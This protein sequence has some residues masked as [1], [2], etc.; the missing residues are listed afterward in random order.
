MGYESVRPQERDRTSRAVSSS[1]G[2]SSR[3]AKRKGERM[4]ELKSA[5]MEWRGGL[6]G[7]RDRRHRKQE[8][9]SRGEVWWSCAR[10][11]T[12]GWCEEERCGGWRRSERVRVYEQ[13]ER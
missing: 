3:D 6:H 13:T 12:D 5:R 7:V 9:A 2:L 1:T 11:E 4:E 8:K 10:A